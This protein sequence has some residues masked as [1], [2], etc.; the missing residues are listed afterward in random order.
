MVSCGDAKKGAVRGGYKTA[1][2]EGI[3]AHPDSV[4]RDM[5]IPYT[6]SITGKAMS[7]CLW[8]SSAKALNGVLMK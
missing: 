1:G 8:V 2:Q 6:K 4:C 5:K 3:I 7:A